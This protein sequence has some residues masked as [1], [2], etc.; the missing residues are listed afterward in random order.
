MRKMTARLL[1]AAAGLALTPLVVAAPGYLPE[2]VLDPLM[3]HHYAHRGLYEKDQS[4]PENSLPAFERA[5]AA[6][7]GS[8]LDVQLSKD[9]QVVVFHDDD[10]KRVCGVDRPVVDLTFAEL[11]EL[12]L[13]GTKE[14][15]PLFTDVLSV[16]AGRTPLIVE[17]KTGK[18]NKELCEKTLAILQSYAGVYCVESFDPS[19]VFWFRRHAPQI[20]RGQLA[21]AKANYNPN[22][23]GGF[24]PVLLSNTCFNVFARPHFIAY[25]VGEKAPL[26]KLSEWM[27]AVKVGWV[28]HAPEEE[29]PYDISIFEWYLP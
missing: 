14:K 28:T 20:V 29:K 11:E 19:I 10:L 24:G 27:G 12:S 2:E 8:E 18:R 21:M 4:I 23:M 3:H 17:L 7:Y 22:A 15:I 16:V 5:C 9:G 26:A 25:Q 1:R 13:C 6:G